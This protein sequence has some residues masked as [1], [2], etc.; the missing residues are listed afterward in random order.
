[1]EV[2][3]FGA[4]YKDEEAPSSGDQ[5]IDVTDLLSKLNLKLDPADTS[6]ILPYGAG[7][8]VALWISSVII[9]A[10]DSLPLFP[11][12]ME[13]VGLGFTVWFSYRYLIFK[14]K[15]DEWFAKID[16]FKEQIL[17]PSDD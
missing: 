9:S 4:G 3:S 16:D 11:K 10:I 12:V 17:G 13:L 5:P 1:M 6:A 8:L 2:A 7:A 15:R 14:N